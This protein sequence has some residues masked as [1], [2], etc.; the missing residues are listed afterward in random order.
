MKFDLVI[1]NGRLVDESGERSAAIGITDG[2]IT[3]IGANLEEGDDEIDAAGRYVIPG[4]VDSHVHLGQLSSKGD[5]TADSFWTGSRSA[6][7]GGTTTVV[8]FAAQHRGMS[9]GAVFEDAM[10]RASAEMAVDYGMHLIVTDWNDS[11]RAELASAAAAGLTAVKMYL[12]YERLKVEG[13]IA[14]ELMGAATAH[15]LPVMVHAELDDLVSQGRDAKLAAGEFGAMS[16]ALS[17]S[18]EA[19][20]LGVTQAIE[21][22]DRAGAKLYLAHIS[23]PQA[24]EIAADARSSGV[25]VIAETCPHYLLLDE[26]N[27]AAPI[28]DAA[29]FMCSPPL[30]S[31]ADRQ[32]L[33]EQLASDRVAI[34]SSDHSPYTADQKLPNGP[35]TKFTEAANGLPGIELRMSLLYTAAVTTGHIAMHDFVRLTAGAPARL[36]GIYPRKGSLAVDADADL[37]IWD[38]RPW[39]VKWD[40]LH[41]DVGYT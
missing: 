26:S 31:E 25:D 24:I 35:S 14:L 32:G 9:I 16:H 30:R 10:Q 41:D 8:P 2:Q 6:L 7:H 29:Q 1:R 22:A 5:L 4:G 13:D 20:W 3:A 23:T 11:A 17:H 33:L 12:T 38:E 28:E 15:G 19:E 18:R 21:L 37:L 40:Q 34:V 36:C 27:Y 39:T